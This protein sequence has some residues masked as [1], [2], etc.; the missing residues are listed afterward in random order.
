MAR[1]LSHSLVGYQGSNG[2]G[3]EGFHSHYY[4]PFETLTTQLAIEQKAS[5]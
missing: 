3:D 5:W 1:S 2:L 4:L